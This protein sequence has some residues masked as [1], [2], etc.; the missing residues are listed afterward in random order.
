MK[1]R[2]SRV[3]PP[4]SLNDAV[5]IHRLRAMGHAQHVIAAK[6]GVNPGRVSEVRSGE[7]F[8]GSRALAAP[9]N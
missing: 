1:V 2:A 9:G 4:L 3:S 8:P 7:R 5:E 6:F